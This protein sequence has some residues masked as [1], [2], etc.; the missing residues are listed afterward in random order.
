MN[1]TH[2]THGKNFAAESPRRQGYPWKSE[3]YNIEKERGE[4]GERRACRKG[5]SQPTFRT[6]IGLGLAGGD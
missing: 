1:F 4:Y 5:L 3:G 6:V 2:V